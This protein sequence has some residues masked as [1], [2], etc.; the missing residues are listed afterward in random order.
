MSSCILVLY[1]KKS[2]ELNNMILNFIDNE[3]LFRNSK[4]TYD[5]IGQREEGKP[6]FIFNNR[7][8]L[9]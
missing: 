1:N 3:F 2:D 8:Y 4:I 6:N 7:I 5:A 9:V